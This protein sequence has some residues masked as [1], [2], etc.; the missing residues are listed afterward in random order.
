MRK[1]NQRGF[2]P[3]ETVLVLVIVGLV[4]FVAWYAFKS[5]SDTETTLGTAANTQ[6]EVSKQKKKSTTETKV[7]AADVIQT[8][9]DSKLGQYLADKDGKT[10]YTYGAD[11]TGVSNCTGTCLTAWPIYKPT[12]SVNLPTSVTVITRSDG[13]TQYA[14]KGLPLYYYTGDTTAGMVTGDGVNNFHIAKP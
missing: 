1:N 14:Y 6:T 4:A 5:K 12:T 2:S 13:S 11:T 9:T 8:K 3:I 10:L 7:T